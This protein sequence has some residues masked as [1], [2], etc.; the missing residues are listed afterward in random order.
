MI[1]ALIITFVV[2]NGFLYSLVWAAGRRTP[3]RWQ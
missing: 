1:V 3:K 2:A